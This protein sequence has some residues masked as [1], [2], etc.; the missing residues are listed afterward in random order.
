MAENRKV[1]VILAFVCNPYLAILQKKLYLKYWKDEV[2][3]VLINVNGR[4]DSIRKFIIDLWKDDDKVAFIVDTPTEIRQGTAFETLYPGVMG[5]V[6]VTMDS[7]NFIYKKGVIRKYSNYILNGE[8]D[9][10]GST[11]YHAWPNS[12]SK[13]CLEKYGTVRLNPFMSFWNVTYINNVNKNNSPSEYK[14]VHFGTHNYLKGDSY[15]PLGGPMPD[16]GWMDI[17]ADFS[18]R[19]LSKYPKY[20]KILQGLE[21]EYYHVGGISS[22][23]RRHFRS[24]EDTNTQKYTVNTE[25]A[26]Q[27]YYSGW[28]N[29]IFE[30]TKND[31]PDK[32]YNEEYLKAHNR[33]LELNKISQDKINKLSNTMKNRN[34]DCFL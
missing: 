12:V 2:D 5:K 7:D 27:M 4:N 18:L 14:D 25:T 21:G 32:E 17:M 26:Q 3:E 11:G 10:I 1:S 31:F 16:S 34:K 8:Y 33:Q 24:L 6:L 30:Y 15:S 9:C 19:Y 23:Y 22:I 28:Y 29:L 13:L 20:L